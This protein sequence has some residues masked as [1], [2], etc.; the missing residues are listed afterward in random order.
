MLKNL[1]IQTIFLYSPLTLTS[2]LDRFESLLI[3]QHSTYSTAQVSVYVMRLPFD[4]SAFISVLTFWSVSKL[5]TRTW[6]GGGLTNVTCRDMRGGSKRDMSWPNLDTVRGSGGEMFF[7]WQR[8]LTRILIWACQNQCITHVSKHFRAFGALILFWKYVHFS[9][10]SRQRRYC[11][12]VR[13]CEVKNTLRRRNF[14]CSR[15][16]CVCVGGL[17]TWHVVT[18]GPPVRAYLIWTRSLCCVLLFLRIDDN[19]NLKIEPHMSRCWLHDTW[20]HCVPV[21]DGACECMCVSDFLRSQSVHFA[22]MYVRAYVFQG[23]WSNS[24]RLPRNTAK[25]GREACIGSV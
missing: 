4:L 1:F 25:N 23:S 22:C 9:K 16:N 14:F 15:K 5:G 24:F 8:L 11:L 3:V 10:F 17:Q 12:S 6:G 2:F 7:T 20:D 18:W 21:K 13:W 19:L